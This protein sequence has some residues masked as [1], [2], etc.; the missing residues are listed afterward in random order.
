MT[1]KQKS[2][3][4]LLE[5]LVALTLVSIVSIPLIQRPVAAYLKEIAALE[6]IELRRLSD[7]A[8]FEVR[9]LLANHTIPLYALPQRKELSSLYP[10][11]TTSISRPPH[12]TQ[13]VQRGFRLYC[14]REKK[15]LDGKTYRFFEIQI[16]LQT[17]NKTTSYKDYRTTVVTP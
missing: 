4:L 7:L 14:L 8:F 17:P 6:S 11:N 16:E 5:L 1:R 13:E 12:R 9:E 15:G 3:F 10:L 2:P